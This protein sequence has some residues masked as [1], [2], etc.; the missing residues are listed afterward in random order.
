MP[1]HSDEELRM[2]AEVVTE[3]AHFRGTSSDKP[4]KRWRN[5]SG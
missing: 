2:I 3:L 1:T 5:R 4:A